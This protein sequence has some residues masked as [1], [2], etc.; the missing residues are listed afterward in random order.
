MRLK[1][2]ISK[3][4]SRLA[5]L[6]R[7]TKG[8]IRVG[9][10]V[11][12]LKVNRPQANKILSNW[13]NQGVLR[14]VSHGLYVPALPSDLGQTQILEDPWI[15][16]PEL[17]DPG[18]VAGWS[19]AEHWELTEQVFR[20]IC[21]LSNKRTEYGNREI[22]GVNFYVKYVPKNLVFGLKTIWRGPLKVSIS[23]PHKTVL[24]MLNDPY[25][26]AGIQHTFDCFKEYL[27]QHGKDLSKILEYADKI[28]S[29]ALFKKLGYFGELK[30]LDSQFIAHC[31][32]RLT[33]GYA[34]LDSTAKNEKLVT[35][36]RIW[37][38]QNW[39]SDD[40]QG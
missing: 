22:Q 38:P 19:A 8:L 24:D 35:R 26:G 15:L 7:S 13:H 4:Q 34:R 11:S 20:S 1:Q 10:V 39:T 33:K 17:F 25:L 12:L 28:N 32:K 18:Y 27:S 16:V 36:W 30:N 23:D 40:H 29:G 21:V 2:V 9:D 14:R 3:R 31:Q 5:E 37:V 6:M